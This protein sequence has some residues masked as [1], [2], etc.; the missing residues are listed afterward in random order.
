MSFDSHDGITGF[1]TDHGT[2]S[3]EVIADVAPD[4]DLYLYNSR[5]DVEHLNMVDHII[6]RGDIDIVSMSM[7]WAGNA[8]PADGT[9][10]VERQVSEARDSGILW[11]NSAG[12][13]GNS[14]WE[15]RFSDPD[16]D[17]L[18]NFSGDDE[19]IDVSVFPGNTFST[20]LTWWDSPSQDYDLYLYDEDFNLLASS[21]NHQPGFDP[22]E[23]VEHTFQSETTAHIV[24]ERHSATEAVDF[25]LFSYWSSFNEHAVARHSI[26][27]PANS[28]DAMAVG[29]SNWWNDILADYSSQGPTLDGRV[30]PDI[31][32]PTC[33]STSTY[34]S[35]CGT[36]AAAPHVAGAAA[37]VM[38][39]YPDATVD[40]VQLLLESTVE[41]RHPKSN[42]D[43]TGRVDVAMLA[44]S[45]VLALYNAN[46]ACNP[47]FFPDTLDVAVGDTVT[48]IN[49]DTEEIRITGHS[50]VGGGFDSGGLLRGET[51]SRT[52]MYDSTV[53]YS[54]SLHPWAAGRVVA[55]AGSP[56][57]SIFSSAGIA[58]PNSIAIA[59][60]KPVT[61]T[62][63]NFVDITISGET[64]ARKFTGISGSGTGTVT[65]AFAGPP[66]PTDATGS[67]YVGTGITDG[68]GNAVTGPFVA[69][70]ADGQAPRLTAVS[71]DS[72]NASPG[73]AVV[74]DVVTL[75]FTASEEITT[76]SVTINGGQAAPA[77]NGGDNWSAARTIDGTDGVGPVTFT[78]D[79]GDVAG[80]TGTRATNTTDS[81]GVSIPSPDAFITLWETTAAGEAITIPVGGAAGTYTVDWGDGSATTHT[82]DATHVYAVPG[83]HM[84][85]I[86]GDFT[87]IYLGGDPGNA[88]K[89]RS[90]A[91][92]GTASWTTME[93]AFA[94]ADN[95]TY[96]AA[97]A[98]DLSGVTD[99]SRMFYDADAF[100]GDISRWDVSN[101]TNM[102]ETFAYA[103]SFDQPLDSWDVSSVAYMGGMFSAAFSFNQPLGSWDVSS[104]L[105]MDEMFRHARSFDQPLGSWDVSSVAY[106]DEMFSAAFSFNQPLGSWDVSSVINMSDMFYAARSFDQNLGDWYIVP[107]DTAVNDGDTTVATIAAQNAFL[108][109]Q[110]PAYAVAPGGDGDL[111]EMLGGALQSKSATYA[112]PSYDVT[113]VSTGGFASPNSRDLTITVGGDTGG[114][115]P[116]VTGTVFTD[117]DGDGTRDAGEP[118]I[119]GY[120]MYAIDLA[121]PETVL[122]AVTGADGAY[123]FA[124]L[125]ASETVVVQ[126]TYFP[127]DHTITTG[128]F[129]RYAHPAGG[130]PVTFDVGFRPV[131]QSEAVT[132]GITA[133][134]DNNGNGARDAGEAA[135]PGVTVHVYTYT[136]N[137]L[138]GITTGTDGTAGKE[139]L[140]PAD[141]LAWVAAVPQ[142]YGVVPTSPVHVAGGVSFY[143]T[144]LASAPA[145]GS[146]V[147]MEVGLVP[148]P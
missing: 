49:A 145:P 6:A 85:Q 110:A 109:A 112:K 87:R 101:T 90:I 80:N 143:G 43:G 92:W 61:A 132:L 89:I 117:A 27:I 81:S 66:V 4:A 29:A 15:G 99:M 139:G 58:A 51:Y 42:Q 74:G 40:E 56:P 26:E 127:F 123:E 52:F 71:M 98:P 63:D 91:Q 31:A 16:G 113:I 97:D 138:Q 22:Y 141:F 79:F 102:S 33:V 41:S 64:D 24:I 23:Y 68:D 131:E 147:P 17:G 75:A 119:P 116:T 130:T 77:S 73:I 128:Q 95:M 54:D 106:M 108:A 118:G 14:H 144:L 67:M 47:C 65:L 140:V 114:S 86:Y 72:S 115:T 3:A 57:P 44:N 135:V 134:Q 69:P 35:Y 142:G 146:T 94:Y 124:G 50:S 30:K 136:T 148:A 13:S 48:W 9:N 126:A 96:S 121:D 36:S 100:N 107:S 37:L 7:A 103:T 25:Q 70:V 11:V 55:G 137:Q 32:G 34:D 59:F 53:S 18:H 1:D 60:S 78:I 105:Y 5:T 129:F 10:R 122:E 20:T 39:K 111:F 83:A 82:G 133:Y 125:D 84:V 76:P 88:A 12:N 104:V 8:W 46:P 93:S 38:Q 28:P 19:T 45:D 2:A 21:E 120:S 62:L